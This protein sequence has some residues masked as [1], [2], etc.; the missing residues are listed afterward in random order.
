MVTFALPGQLLGRHHQLA[1]SRVL[2]L[3]Q[4]GPGS[5]SVIWNDPGHQASTQDVDWLRT[6]GPRCH[7][8]RYPYNRRFR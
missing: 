1:M 7:V 2:W 5:G 8:K 4:N 3:G 6:A